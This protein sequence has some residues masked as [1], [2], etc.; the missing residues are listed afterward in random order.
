MPDGAPPPEPD[1]R[2]GMPHR[3]AR[4]RAAVE[5]DHSIKPG[6]WNDSPW[7]EQ[8]RSEFAQRLKWKLPQSTEEQRAA[9][10]EETRKR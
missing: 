9:W 1:A 10:V 5:L 2:A 4:I 7:H 3:V 6:E 8:A